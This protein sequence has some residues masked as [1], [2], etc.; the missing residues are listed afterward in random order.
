MKNAKRMVVLVML[1]VST[2]MNAQVSVNVNIGTP[3]L[4]GPVGYTN[5]NYYYL[6]D[7][8]AYY[9][10]PSAMFIFYEGGAWVHRVSLPMMYSSYDLYG[11]YKV[12]MTD[13]RGNQ[14]YIHFK[15]Y[16]VKYKKGY[17]GGAQKTIGE[18]PG[19]GNA[20]N[21]NKSPANNN[22][23][24]ENTKGAERKE[25]KSNAPQHNNEKKGSK[26]NGGGND[27]KQGGGG[28]GH[29]K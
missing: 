24:Q 9:D 22:R 23:K 14:P 18:R 5:V 16:R 1:F 8:E 25:S 2:I 15:E 4:W 19:K 20:N 28:N 29:K 10:I 3:P 21:G 17:R 27:R 26:S 11:G 6:P 7:V 12:V 13:Y